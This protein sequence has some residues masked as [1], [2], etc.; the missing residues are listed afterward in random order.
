VLRDHPRGGIAVTAL[1]EG[2]PGHHLQ[3][4]LANRTESTARRVFW[5]PVFAE[6]WALYCEEMMWEEGFYTDPRERLL[7]LKDL[8]WRACR[9]VVDIALHTRGWSPEEAVDYLVREA[10]LEPANARVEVQRYC[11][12][13]T[14]PLSY[15]VGKREILSLRERWRALRGPEAPLREFHDHLLAWGTIPPPLIAQAMGLG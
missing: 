4:S 7:Q 15:A 6:G 11:A 5:T 9:V 14:Q 3:F 12:E 13:A 8:L 2:Y 1:H 10:A